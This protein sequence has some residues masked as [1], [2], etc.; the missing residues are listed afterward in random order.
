MREK[1]LDLLLEIAAALRH[2]FASHKLQEI[3]IRARGPKGFETGDGFQTAHAGAHSAFAHETKESNLT[4]TPGVGAAAEFHAVT[5]E[6]F[7]LAADL[8]D[9]HLIAVFLAEEMHDAGV[10]LHLGVGQLGP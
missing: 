2:D 8:H 9:A 6:L 4:G 10:T 1:L 5:I 3:C 7:R